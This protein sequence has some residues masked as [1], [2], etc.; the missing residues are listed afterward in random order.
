MYMRSGDLFDLV[1][2][3]AATVMLVIAISLMAVLLFVRRGDR[4]RQTGAQGAAH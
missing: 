2:A 1:I 3:A 4:L